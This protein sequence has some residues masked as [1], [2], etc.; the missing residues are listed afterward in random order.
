VISREEFM[1]LCTVLKVQWE[2][3]G[4]ATYLERHWPALYRSTT[5][6]ALR[7]A[8]LSNVFQWG[9]LRSAGRAEQ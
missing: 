6:Q 7:R 9:A 8:V 2:E 3:E 1:E 4:R 5:F